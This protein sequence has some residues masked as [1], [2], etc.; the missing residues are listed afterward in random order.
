VLLRRDVNFGP[1]LDFRSE[2][3]FHWDV[4]S[5]VQAIG[6]FETT[7]KQADPYE[8][9]EIDHM[10][11]VDAMQLTQRSL[12]RKL[13]NPLS[14]VVFE[15]GGQEEQQH[16]RNCD[17][18]CESTALFPTP[19]WARSGF[20]YPIVHASTWVRRLTNISATAWL[21]YVHNTFVTA[22]ILA[23]LERDP[24]V[25]GDLAKRASS[26]MATAMSADACLRPVPEG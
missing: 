17:T 25:C 20:A 1:S 8:A 4:V 13:R 23:L 9:A 10:G 21:G 5:Q 12:E 16:S 6:F 3:Q 2:M 24:G 15:N 22:G 7:C 26:L 19:P 14:L 11:L 18:I